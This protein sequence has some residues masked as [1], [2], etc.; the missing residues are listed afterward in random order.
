MEKL[1]QYKYIILITLLA[2]GF[3]FYW[4][5]YRPA[6]ARM[7]CSDNARQIMNTVYPDIIDSDEGSRLNEAFYRK[8]MRSSFGLEK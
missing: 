8:C 3:A 7:E 6:K 1:R 5:E 4:Y 2:L